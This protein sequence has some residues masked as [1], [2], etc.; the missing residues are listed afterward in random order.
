MLSLLILLIIRL[1]GTSG[2]LQSSPFYHA[3]QVCARDLS[4]PPDR[5]EQ[6]RLLIFPDEPYTHC[7]VR[8][9]LM[10]IRAWHD[11]TGVRHSALQQYFTPE[12]HPAD[13]YARVQSCL[14]YV[15]NSCAA[16]DSCTK[17]YW[18]L[19]CY[20]QQFGSYF[21]SREQF[22]PATDIQLAQTMFDCADKL[23]IPRS[24]VAEYRYGNR[25]ELMSCQNPCFVRCVAIS[26]DLY[27]DDAG[28]Q[29]DHV[30]V[31]LGFNEHRE[32]Y[33]EKVH[34]A[35]SE[36]ELNSMDRCAAATQIIEPILLAAL[37]E[38]KTTY[39]TGVQVEFD[40]RTI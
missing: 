24:V 17:A 31:Q 11:Q 13:A 23:D 8:C 3:L 15:A 30:Y 37:Q 2:M 4:V 19:N 26:I 27:D 38:S 16:I 9:I 32:N 20:K 12:D 40:L 33:L 36:L 18:S 21:F 35:V 25:S 6:Y 14:E 34:Q 10:G 7:F 29:W 1:A 5:Y 22:V 28:L 39:R